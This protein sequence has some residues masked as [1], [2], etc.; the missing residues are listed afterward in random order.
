MDENHWHT[1]HQAWSRLTPPLRP[2]PNVVTAVKEQIKRRPGRTILLG[3]TPEL[4]DVAPDL[5]AVDRN[6]AMVANIWPGNS[7]V[8]QA[9]VGDW[10][11]LSFS[12]NTFSLCVGDG[13]LNNLD[14]F[15]DLTKL[16]LELKRIMI[17]GGRLV[18]RL[19]L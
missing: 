9:I 19:Y 15:V 12:S 11:E 13:S 8:R 7:A 16:F 14:H 3:V 1:Y 2:H 6:P 10:R 18:C 17:P 5:V 4:A